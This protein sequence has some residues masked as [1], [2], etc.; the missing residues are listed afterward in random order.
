M[1]APAR[2][3]HSH[4]TLHCLLRRLL[5]RQVVFKMTEYS[6]LALGLFQSRAEMHRRVYTH[7]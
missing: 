6:N 5:R 4:A 7:Q 2:R 1:C 3:T